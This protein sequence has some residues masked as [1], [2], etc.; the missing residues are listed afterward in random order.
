[1][2]KPG[3]TNPFIG[4]GRWSLV[5]VFQGL[6]GRLRA[7]LKIKPWRTWKTTKD[8]RP[9]NHL[10]PGFRS[11]LASAKGNPGSWVLMPRRKWHQD[12]PGLQLLKHYPAGLW[13]G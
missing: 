2:E 7:R 8:N 3:R 1:M 13:P 6:Q 12:E 5:E 4:I 10:G 9:M 11:S